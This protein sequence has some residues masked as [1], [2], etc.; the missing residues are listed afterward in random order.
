MKH[1]TLIAVALAALAT[2]ATAQIADGDIPALTNNVQLVWN[3]NQAAQIKALWNEDYQVRLAAYHS[4]TN[5]NPDYAT[6]AAPT[7]A[8]FAVWAQAWAKPIMAEQLALKDAQR[9][10]RQQQALATAYKEAQDLF[11]NS[12]ALLTPAQRATQSN[13]WWTAWSATQ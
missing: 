5:T 11:A 9:Q 8:V 7:R 12:W 2:T 6:N 1:L 13:V 3:T 10:W 4:A